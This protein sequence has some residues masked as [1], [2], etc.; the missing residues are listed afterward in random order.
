MFS[1][2][3]E[4]SVQTVATA[5]QVWK[6]WTDHENWQMWDEGVDWVKAD[7]PFNS[8][9]T[10]LLKPKGGPAIQFQ[11]LHAEPLK[12]FHDRSFLPLTRLDFIHSFEE[13]SHGKQARIIHRIEMHGI[14][15]PLFSRIIGKNIK[16]GLLPALRKLVL[17]A[18]NS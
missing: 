6:I 18:E 12:G 4:E 1:W 7:G 17:L 11:I 10:G 9:T 8:G 15:A 3:F 13:A 14:L 2:V 16:A 5:E